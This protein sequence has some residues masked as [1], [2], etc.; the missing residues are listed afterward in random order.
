MCRQPWTHPNVDLANHL[1][2][3]W[4]EYNFLGRILLGFFLV[5]CHF[6]VV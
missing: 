1:S 2:S 4:P 6:V 5:I 3:R